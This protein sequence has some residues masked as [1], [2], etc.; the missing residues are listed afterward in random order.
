MPFTHNPDPPYSYLHLPELIEVP[1][2]N[3]GNSAAER[4]TLVRICQG[5]A[6]FSRASFSCEACAPFD[7]V[8]FGFQF[9]VVRSSAGI[10]N[11]EV[12]HVGSDVEVRLG[13]IGGRES[14]GL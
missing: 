9:C 6:R 14:E 2:K 7:G 4:A 8:S 11:G 5:A 1:K 13:G 10:E 12:E 3:S